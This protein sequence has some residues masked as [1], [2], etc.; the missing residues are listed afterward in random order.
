MGSLTFYSSN[1]LD[2]MFTFSKTLGI[3]FEVSKRR[4]S[5]FEV[6]LGN[7]ITSF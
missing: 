1:Y 5:F 4:N 3:K 7:S 2:N 6:I